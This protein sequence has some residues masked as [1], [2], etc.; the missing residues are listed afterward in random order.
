MKTPIG[1]RVRVE[2]EKLEVPIVDTTLTPVRVWTSG[3]VLRFMVCVTVCLCLLVYVP[4]TF[5]L[6]QRGL[7]GPTLPG[8]VSGGGLLGLGG[9]LF[10]ILQIS[11]R[12]SI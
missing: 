6:I 5:Y 3:E 12:R 1:N 2:P 10:K 9:L 4:W 11:L 8:A 7:V